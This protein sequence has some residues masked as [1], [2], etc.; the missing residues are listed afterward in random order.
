MVGWA[1]SQSAARSCMR[2]STGVRPES[3]E[4]RCWEVV[5]VAAVVGGDAVGA[6]RNAAM[7]GE[8][9]RRPAWPP[10]RS[11]V[12]VPEGGAAVLERDRA[13]GSDTG[14]HHGDVAVKVTDWPKTG[15]CSETRTSAWWSWCLAW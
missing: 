6:D 1:W 11:A 5:G 7:R 3:Q 10:R 4:S 15:G 14:A 13:S 9:E 8:V 2:D 12:P